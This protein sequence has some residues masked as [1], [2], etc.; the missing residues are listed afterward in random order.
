MVFLIGMMRSCWALLATLALLLPCGPIVAQ[1]QEN[2]LEPPGL[3]NYRRWGFLRARPGIQLTNLGYDSNILS[4]SSGQV[5][6]DITAT[7]SP[8]LDGLIL[9][10]SKA[11]VTLSEQFD[12][13]L[14][15]ENSDQNYWNNAFASRV[16][17]PFRKFGVFADWSID[18][19]RF[20]PVD[21]EDIRIKGE[22][23]ELGVGMILQPGWR[24]EIEIGRY[25]RR[26]RHEDPQSQ[27]LA[28]PVNERLDRDE[29]RTSVDLSYHLR[30]RT[31][32]LLHVEN[33]EI[34]FRFPFIDA[35]MQAIQRD[36]DEWR[37]LV[38]FRL[39]QGASVIGH[40]LL[41]WG[42]I[43]ATDPRLQDL[44]EVIGE[45]DATWIAGS[46]TRVRLRGE[47]TPGFSVSQ[48]NAYYLDTVGSIRTV[49]F[50]T[51]FL[52]GE[53]GLRRGKLDF[54]E[55]LS[56]TTRQDETSHYELGVRLRLLE[57]ADGRRI[58]YSL[59]VGRYERDSTIDSF[60]QDKT[61]F[62]FGAVLG[63]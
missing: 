34:E 51:H 16:T 36:T 15:A 32:A 42:R 2:K 58:E 41:G 31:S 11:F 47:R 38:G 5:V 20:R 49:H 61:T 45:L 63:F 62:G 53:V 18:D 30:G 3:E 54:P 8:K 57:S 7:L 29:Q 50:F 33:K 44:S 21:Q 6:S 12:Y 40:L 59:T 27:P 26:S 4:R 13:T 39:G 22:H 35:Q 48:G 46:R 9:F 17:M 52:G 19:L 28:V 24:T 43:D 37:S 25:A 55:A 60:D 56:G 1:E 23:R 14:Y 10:G